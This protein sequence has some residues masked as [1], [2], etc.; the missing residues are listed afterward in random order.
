M[1]YLNS[2][3]LATNWRGWFCDFSNGL[4]CRKPEGETV[5]FDLPMDSRHLAFLAGKC[6]DPR[7]GDNS[8]QSDWVVTKEWWFATTFKLPRLKRGERAFLRTRG[9]DHLAQYFVNG[10]HVG[11]SESFNQT[12]FFDITAALRPG[13]QELAIRLWAYDPP[14][15]NWDIA[16]EL[17]KL[18]RA[19]RRKLLSGRDDILKTI[20][21]WG[22]DHSPFLMSC[23]IAIPPEIITAKNVLIR[24]VKTDYVFSRP[25]SAVRG[26]LVL[27]VTAWGDADYEVK[28][29]PK[30]FAGKSYA[31]AGRWSGIEDTAEV[32]FKSL[33][34]KPWHP[35]H[36]GFP[37]CYDLVVKA[38][39]QKVCVT[40][41]FRKLE[42]RHNEAFK[43]STAPSIM[44]WQPYENNSS[45]GSAYYKGYD[46]IREAGEQWPEKPREGSYRYTHLVNGQEIF[47]MGGAVVPTNLFLSDW[48]GS[49]LRGLV[50]RARESNN[51]T[52]RVWGGGYLSG[53]EFF[54][55]ADLQGVMIS[56]D[57]LFFTRF[58]NRSIER[59][60]Q[61]ER[62]CRSIIR[63]LN[64]HP[65]VVIVNGGNELLQC[66]N[67]PID[68]AFQCMARVTAQESTNQFFH[69]SS[70]V[71]PEMHGAWHADLDHPARYNS[72]RT[73]MCTECGVLAAPNV[74][75]MRHALTAEQ[76]ADAFGKVWR[77][78]QP[79]AGYFKNLILYTELFGPKER[80]AVPDVVRRTQ[81]MQ[82]AGCQYI[83]E[84]FRRRKPEVSG[85][86]TWEF[87]EPWLDFNWGIVDNYLVPKHSFWT[88]KRA[89]AQHLLSARFASFAYAAGEPFRAEIF[90]SVEGNM[91]QTV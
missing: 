12:D 78:R 55:E 81:W 10:V 56:Q 9:V 17:D 27:D 63:E 52:L 38:G 58:S 62:E 37:H 1:K 11:G 36:L 66:G 90:Y 21:F 8:L 18:D 84:E 2:L 51:N 14:A 53:E 69:V 20:M 75:S 45:Y 80:V 49:Y 71:N 57:F 7:P 35:F 83:A 70:P 32:P 65:S 13:E 68:P 50:R 67:S 64:P 89:C 5:A 26:R 6:A 31:L 24:S 79:Y 74:K 23:G 30:N 4:E 82:A 43:S 19:A 60:L 33:S 85:F 34:V 91:K 54:E 61:I 25:H 46:A 73:I 77:H 22:G 41:G 16:K 72:Y 40:T 42:R 87:N 28:L 59:L 3:K 44:D 88:F 47:V 76:A 29:A 48:R 86:T 15:V 39:G